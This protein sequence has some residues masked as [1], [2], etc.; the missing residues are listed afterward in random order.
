M[1]NEYLIIKSV[2]EIDENLYK[3]QLR[4]TVLNYYRNA[5]LLLK[6]EKID[7]KSSPVEIIGGLNAIM[8]EIDAQYRMDNGSGW[9]RIDIEDRYIFKCYDHLITILKAPL[10]AELKYRKLIKQSLKLTGFT[11]RSKNQIGDMNER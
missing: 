9:G 6:G 5:A 11:Y 2:L 10:K 3:P 1:I 4:D 8:P 7:W